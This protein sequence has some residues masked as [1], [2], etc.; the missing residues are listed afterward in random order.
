LGNRTSQEA[1]PNR[2]RHPI[3]RWCRQHQHQQIKGASSVPR[4]GSQRRVY[5]ASNAKKTAQQYRPGPKF[6]QIQ[7]SWPIA[8]PLGESVESAKQA[9]ESTP[10]T[11]LGETRQPFLRLPGDIPPSPRDHRKDA[12][13]SEWTSLGSPEWSPACT[14]GIAVFFPGDAD[15]ER[16]PE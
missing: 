4:E 11:A 16:M 3:L 5:E 6:A 12:V 9:A 7:T 14:A 2:R 10:P 8:E 1:R 13:P 15:Q